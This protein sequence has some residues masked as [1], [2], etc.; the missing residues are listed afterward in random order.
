MSIGVIYSASGVASGVLGPLTRIWLSDCTRGNACGPFGLL[1]GTGELLS[2]VAPGGN[3]GNFL[4]FVGLAAVFGPGGFERATR[5]GGGDEFL[6]GL[7]G[8]ADSSTGP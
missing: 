1:A 6:R 3:A 8:G 2:E 4:S 7:T 5:G